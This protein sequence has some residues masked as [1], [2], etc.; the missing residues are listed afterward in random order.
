[1]ILIA[2]VSYTQVKTGCLTL[3]SEYHA[4]DPLRFCLHFMFTFGCI[5]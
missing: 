4:S 1:M 2:L 5:S 3:K